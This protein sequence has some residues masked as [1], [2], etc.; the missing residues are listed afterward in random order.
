MKTQVEPESPEHAR[1]VV[2]GGGVIGCTILYH[3]A[4]AGWKDL[5]LVEE[6]NLTSGSTWHAA[7]NG[8]TFNA[9]PLW[10]WAMKRTFQLWSEIEAESG[11]AVGA[12]PVGGVMIARTPERMDELRRLRGIGKRIGVDYEMLTP[13]ELLDFWPVFNTDTVLGALYDPIGGHVDPYGLTQAYARAARQRG[14]VVKQDWKVTALSPTPAG[15]WIVKGPKGEIRADMIINAAGLYADEVARM[16]GA[17]L[18]MINMRHHYLLTEPIES[19]GAIENEPPVFRDVDAGVYGRREGGGILF[20]IYEQDCRDFGADGMPESFISQLF[21]PDFDRLEP[22]LEHVFDAIPCIAENG[23]KS[24]VHGPFVFT[25]DVRPLLGWMPGQA[26][27]FVAAGFLAG[28][29]MSGGFGQLIAEWIVDGA[30]HR[31]LAPCDVLR[32]GDWAV[33]DFARARGHDAYATRYKMHFPNEEI[34]AGRPVRT[35]PLHERYRSLGAHFGM[36]DGWERPNWFAGAGREPVETPTFRR[37]EAHDAVARECAHVQTAAGYV[38]LITYANHLIEGPGA[39]AFLRRVLPGR[40]PKADGQLALMPLIDENAGTIGDATV[41]RL[42]SEQFMMVGSGP[43]SRIHLRTLM[44]FAASFDMTFQNRTESW[45]GFSVAGPRA[46]DVVQAALGGGSAPAF[47]R[48]GRYRIAEAE[49]IVLRLSYVGE[50]S[51][52]IHCHLDDQAALHERLSA[53]AETVGVD[54]L[55]FGTRAM[56]AMRI[57]KGLPRSGD[58]LTIEATPFEL[59]MDWMLDRDRNDDFIGKA[60]LEA[61]RDQP[62]R[63]RLVSMVLGDT[64]VDPVGGE[65]VVKDGDLVG[66]VS[67]ASYGHR[68]GRTVALGFLNPALCRDGELVDVCVLDKEVAA[69]VSLTCAYDPEGIR[70]RA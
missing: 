53:A 43:L 4:A 42:G 62:L 14:A 40:V 57:E 25:P 60:A 69:E 27:H 48:G 59:G 9:S 41:L 15:A 31:D 70:A 33:G 10:A 51:Y 8:N 45:S 34:S 35:P 23:I 68:L 32:F 1:V 2:I 67:S 36:S 50:L 20:G 61:L 17:R 47:F 22:E 5:V 19:V 52:E 18:P 13:R 6:A 26:N 16:T 37:S 49:C 65:P 64:D 63:Y 29:A 55:P 30:P 24:S 21:D 44:P 3:L 11:Q 46:R 58:E 7:A 56:N 38:D 54:L 39:E 66:Y 28:I 12:H